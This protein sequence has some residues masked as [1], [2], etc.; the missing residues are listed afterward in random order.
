MFF[1]VAAFEARYQLRQPAFWVICILFGLMG[2]GVVAASENIS[3]GGGGAVHVNSPYALSVAH[4]AFNP[5]FMLATAAIVA[6]AVAR[7]A[8][9]GFGPLIQATRLNRFDYLYGRFA[10]AFAVAALAYGSI[11]LGIAFGTLMPWVDR[12]TLGPFR[13]GE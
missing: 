7:D 8:Q 4:F 11:G 10:G 2:F 1:K 5:F 13:P 12:E 9:T 6:N 3:L